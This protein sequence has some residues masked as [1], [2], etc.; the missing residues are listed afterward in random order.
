MNYCPKCKKVPD[1]DVFAKTCPDCG[2][3]TEEI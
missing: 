1:G 2:G 3:E